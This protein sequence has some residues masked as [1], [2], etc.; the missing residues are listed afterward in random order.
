MYVADKIH[1]WNLFCI[2]THFTIIYCKVLYFAQKILKD[3]LLLKVK[4]KLTKKCTL[5]NSTNLFSLFLSHSLFLFIQLLT[6]SLLLSLLSIFFSLQALTLSLVFSLLSNSS[7]SL[8]LSSSLS[9]SRS[10]PS[11]IHTLT[12]TSFSLTLSLHILSLSLSLSFSL[13][14]Y[15]QITN[16]IS[17]SHSISHFDEKERQTLSLSRSPPFF[18]PISASLSLFFVSVF[19]SLSFSIYPNYSLSISLPFLTF[20]LSPPPLNYSLSFPPPFPQNYTVSL[21]PPPF[22]PY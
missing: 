13:S 6:L 9:F 11:I 16:S 3:V 15:T 2:L 14:L 20:Y 4:T 21:S 10:F 17:L 5:W 19:D 12:L 7:T 1:V 8:T 18:S 22:P